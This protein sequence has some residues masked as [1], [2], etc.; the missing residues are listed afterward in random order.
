MARTRLIRCAP[1]D[2]VRLALKQFMKAYRDAPLDTFLL[3]PTSAACGR[4]VD[5]LVKEGFSVFTSRICTLADLAIS[6]FESHMNRILLDDPSEEIVIGRILSD[7]PS[8]YPLFQRSFKDLTSIIP[9]LLAFIST[10]DE[11]MIDQTRTWSDRQDKRASELRELWSEYK[12]YLSESG[13]IDTR[14]FVQAVTEAMKEGKGLHIKHLIVA[15]FYEPKPLETHLIS[16]LMERADEATVVLPH[17]ET[18]SVSLDDGSWLAPG[19]IDDVASPTLVRLFDD[20]EVKLDRELSVAEFKD[21]L[22]EARHVAQEIGRLLLAGVDPSAVCVLLPRRK[23]MYPV[24]ESAFLEFQTPYDLAFSKDLHESMAVTAVLGLLDVV[25]SGYGREEVVRLLKSP[26][27]KF[28][29]D[30]DGNKERI[31]GSRLDRLSREAGVIE[32]REN[33][34]KQLLTLAASMREEASSPEVPPFR[35]EAMNRKAEEAERTARLLESLFERLSGIEG[36]MSVRARCG[37]LRGILIEGRFSDHLFCSE[38][39]M[40]YRDGRASQKLL[41]ALESMEKAEHLLGETKQALDEFI[42]QLR[43]VASAGGFRDR[44][45]MEGAVQISGLRASYLL[46]Y[47]HVFIVGMND[48]DIP[49]LGAG[50]AFISES[51]VQELGLLT[52]KDLLRQERFYFLSSLLCGKKSIH[53]SRPL[54]VD[55]KPKVASCFLEDIQRKLRP[56]RWGQDEVIGSRLVSQKAAGEMIGGKRAVDQIRTELPIDVA[57]VARRKVIEDEHRTEDYDSPFDAMLMDKKVLAQ[58][59]AKFTED[60]IF[61]PS[62]LESYARCPFSYYMK[63]VL[64]LE[65]F[66]EAALDLDAKGRGSLFHYIAYRFYS[67]LRSKGDTRLDPDNVEAY[68]SLISEI[69]EQEMALYSFSG[70]RWEASRLVMLG[71]EGGRRGLLRAF[72]ENEV[73][74]AYPLSPTLFE[75]SFGRRPPQDCDPASSQAPMTIKLGEGEPSQLKLAGRIDRIDMD[76]QKRFFIIDYKTGKSPTQAE[77]KKGK[78]LQ[79]P[80]YMEAVRSM[81]PGSR[82]LGAAYYQVKSEAKLGLDTVIAGKEEEEL[83]RKIVGGKT[84]V[85]SLSEII[86]TA[87]MSAQA[88][89]QGM[90]SGRFHP[91][92][93]GRDC[94]DYCEYWTVCRFDAMRMEEAEDEAER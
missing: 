93:S 85:P 65:P 30:L 86:A 37:R 21:P 17:P 22:D 13:L 92:M 54:A 35:V 23:E 71:K 45:R 75:L 83:V 81:M 94:S 68:V 62:A 64:R 14:S 20:D 32:G 29:I 56:E 41:E 18:R 16:R 4:A 57:E 59:D 42:S 8:K 52:R 70:A 60:A 67:E 53:L 44:P 10:I 9:E 25:S 73:A 19:K 33:W 15:G 77:I 38:R 61:S 63:N 27:L 47:D 7:N 80:L 11:F 58:L 1:D 87:K 84:L 43:L 66:P 46:S 39:S 72:V 78:A 12:R 69:A 28:D 82:P 74:S 6:E 49:F 79:L 88:C 50:N 36:R 90:R 51:D 76:E 5:L 89:V 3:M 40:V 55:G 31:S 2:V 24:I 91:A 34:S 26:Y 48:G